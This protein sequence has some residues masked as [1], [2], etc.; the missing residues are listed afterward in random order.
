MAKPLAKLVAL[1]TPK[2]RWAQFSLATMFVVV[3]ALCVWLSVVANRAHRQ[4][5]AV[6]AIEALGGRV[7]YVKPDRKATEAFPTPFLRRWLSRDYFDDVRAVS[8]SGTQVTDAGLA[9]LQGLTRLRWLDL[10]GTRVTDVGLA[11]L[12]GLTGLQELNLDSTQITDAGLA[13]LQGLMGLRWLDLSGT[14]VTDVGMSHLQGL[15]SLRRLSFSSTQVT[16]IGLA[17]LQVLTRLEW[18]W[19]KHSQ[20]TDAALAQ[21]RQ[22]LPNCRMNGL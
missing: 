5:D 21:F 1:I 19:L 18:L 2:R 22:A 12:H 6:A 8:L 14:Q 7:G 10:S 15:A 20:V 3:T 13:H 17:H 16:D 11:Q 9:H 4:R